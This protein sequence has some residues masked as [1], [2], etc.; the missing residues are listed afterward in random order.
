[1]TNIIVGHVLCDWPPC[2][3][4]SYKGLVVNEW[5]YATRDAPHH[6]S[7]LLR[8]GR[9][10]LDEGS[11]AFRPQV[12]ADCIQRDAGCL[13]RLAGTRGASMWSRLTPTK[14]TSFHLL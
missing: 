12:C 13:Q 6:V 3:R 10:P 8:F 5:T 2:C 7:V 1:M 9:T 14:V 4:S 11:E